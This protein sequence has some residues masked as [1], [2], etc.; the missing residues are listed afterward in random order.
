MNLGSSGWVFAHD[1]LLTPF[2]A[3]D[4]DGRWVLA[5]GLLLYSGQDTRELNPAQ[6]LLDA[7]QQSQ[8]AFLDAL[9]DYGGRHLVLQ[10]DGETVALYQDATGMRTIYV[11]EGAALV[12]SHANLIHDVAPHRERTL[13]EG[14]AGF[15]T[16][17]GRSPWVGIEALLPNHSLTLGSW[18]IERFFP[19]AEN[20]YEHLSVADRVSLFQ[21]KWDRM[22]LDL[23]NQNADLIMSLTGGWDSRT[24]MAL[25]RAHLDRI[26]M[27]TYTSRTPGD[28]L[29][30]GMIARDEAVVDKLLE[31]IPA[32]GHTYFHI[33]DRHEKLPPGQQALV[34]ANSVGNHFKWLLPHYMRS[35]PGDKVIHIRG[36]ASAVGKSSW[37]DLKSVNSQENLQK[38]YLRRTKKDAGH[39]PLNQ[40]IQ[41]FTDGYQRW[42]YHQNLY[43]F[44]R[45]DLYYWEI[46]LGR[47]SAEICNETDVA[48]ETC[49]AMNVRSLLEMTLSFPIEQRKESFLFAELINQVF[50]IL[51]FVGFND[52][53]NLYEIVR[54]SAVSSQPSIPE[55]ATSP[56]APTPAH[57]SETMAGPSLEPELEVRHHGAV[58]ERLPALT[59]QVH[60]PIAH[61]R[62]GQLVSRAFTPMAASGTLKFTVVSRYGHERGGGNWRY[63]VW[64]NNRMLASWD[65][66]ISKAPVH[67]SVDG[68]EPGDVVE[69]V[70]CPLRD[71]ERESWER[72]S[73]I[74]LQEVAFEP[75]A[76]LR[77]VTVTADAP[78]ALLRRSLQDT[79]FHVGDLTA[80]SIDD[81]AVDVPTRL[82]VDLGTDV[83]P[84]LVVRR[85]GNRAVAMF[86]G[87]V[88]TS[89]TMGAPAFQRSSWWPKINIH[90]IH[91]ADPASTGPRALRTSWGQLQPEQSAIPS[92][93][94]AIK[95]VAEI[96]GAGQADDRTYFG[97]SSGGFWAWNAAILDAGSRAVVS[98]PQTDWTRWSSAS[99]ADL[100]AQR[101]AGQSLEGFR[102]SHPGRC[103]VLEA[104]RMMHHP[105][106]VDYWV[107]TATPYEAQVELPRVNSFKAQHPELAANLYI[108]EYC[109]E[110]AI[111][112][113]LD[114]RSTIAAI[115]AD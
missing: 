29:R 26:Q 76:A 5:H 60:L 1:P 94:R 37:T 92:A 52:E 70:G 72:A 20:R 27:F 35:F 112:S 95:A 49:A 54:D 14:R 40:R 8:T 32:A 86:D 85:A 59:D 50:P 89:T 99:S 96:L 97:S 15:M 33:E 63:Q 82:E 61:F 102:H 67:V 90:Q 57:R 104:W 53:R 65:G 115:L 105:T 44:H 93:V 83:L 28:D 107:N 24:S 91:V 4:D 110:K 12:S 98:N 7:W 113:P 81:F 101:F 100:L 106:R 111:H 31:H 46:R 48:F 41:E 34:D 11:S 30:K 22:M 51:N 68:L 78:G 43:G 18:T 75:A 66:G 56:D 9:D 47:W 16:A 77:S 69:V 42:G 2:W 80:L 64:V 71:H 55:P 88:D 74:W 13:A 21:R 58:V 25:S 109:H 108:H 3:G 84:L 23:T 87:P 79:Y 45:R 10:G 103:D 62:S 19:R 39:M 6:R 38:Y 114:Q 36:N 17:W 73:R